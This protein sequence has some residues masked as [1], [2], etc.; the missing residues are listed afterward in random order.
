MRGR[1]FKLKT[2]HAIF[3]R[4]IQ[5]LQGRLNTILQETGAVDKLC[6]RHERT[7]SQES[8]ADA[9]KYR[10]C[11]C[12]YNPDP[13]KCAVRGDAQNR[14]HAASKA[15]AQQTSGGTLPK[16]LFLL[17]LPDGLQLLFKL[18]LHKITFEA[19]MSS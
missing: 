8:K 19:L 6:R 12:Q 1:I 18:V 3:T 4:S 16:P 9:N 10:Q 2:A 17:S 15:S 13:R 7:R 14:Q 5:E 11:N